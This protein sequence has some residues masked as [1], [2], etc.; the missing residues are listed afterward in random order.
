VTDEPQF[1]YLTTTGWKSGK[2]HEIEIWYVPH[3][4]RYYLVSEHLEGS[5]WVQ[6]IRRNPAIT[7][8][9]G[10]QSFTGTGRIVDPEREPDLA[11]AVSRLMDEKYEWSTGTIVELAPAEISA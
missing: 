4:G 9:V 8:R 7:F 11:K 5:H 2:L 10:E 1:L 3:G 6:N